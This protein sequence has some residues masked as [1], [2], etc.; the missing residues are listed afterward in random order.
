MKANIGQTLSKSKIFQKMVFAEIH[1]TQLLSAQPLIG[2]II[3][4][5]MLIRNLYFLFCGSELRML[6]TNAS[7]ERTLN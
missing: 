6:L 7:N 4:I 1:K 2:E 5:E 3:K